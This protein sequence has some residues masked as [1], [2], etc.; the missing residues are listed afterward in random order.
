MLLPVV[1]GNLRVDKD[2]SRQGPI[3]VWPAVFNS[4]SKY[5]EEWDQDKRLW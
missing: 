2:P 1:N 4:G 3:V 5:E